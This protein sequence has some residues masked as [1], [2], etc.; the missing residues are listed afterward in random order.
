[1]QYSH[2][3][4][5]DFGHCESTHNNFIYKKVQLRRVPGTPEADGLVVDGR[6]FRL[7]AG[8]P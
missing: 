4:V 8:T 3:S 1:M 5:N 2:G 7:S 6:L